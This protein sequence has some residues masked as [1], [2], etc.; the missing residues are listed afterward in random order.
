MQL[1]IKDMNKKKMKS[2]Q[3]ND[4]SSL[5]ILPKKPEKIQRIQDKILI[6]LKKK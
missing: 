2:K 3:N 1:K 5:L 6:K 4:Y